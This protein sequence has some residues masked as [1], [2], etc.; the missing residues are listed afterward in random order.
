[1]IFAMPAFLP[2]I[3]RPITRSFFSLTR[4][5]NFSDQESESL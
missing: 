5:I 4:K 2:F 1:M 3:S